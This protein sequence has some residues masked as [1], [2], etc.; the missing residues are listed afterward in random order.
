MPKAMPRAITLFVSVLTLATCA[1]NRQSVTDPREDLDWRAAPAMTLSRSAHAVV[2]DEK[3]IYALG[4]TGV[5]RKPVLAVERFD[6]HE[7]KVETKLPGIGLN[8]PAAAMHN[9]IIYL[10]GGFNTTTNVPSAFVWTY[11]TAGKNWRE[12]RPLPSPRGGHAA[13]VHNGNIHVV[14]GGNAVSTISDHNVFD[15]ATETWRTLAPLPKTTGSPALVSYRGE[16]YAIG[17][18][19]GDSDFGETYVYNT[20]SN[21]WRLGTPV[22]PRGTAGAV[23]ACD[24]IYLIGG[25]SQSARKV[26]NDVLR[27]NLSAGQWEKLTPLRTARNFARAVMLGRDI[28]VVGGNLTIEG[29][30]ESKG[31]AI[32]ERMRPHC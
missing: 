24:A 17:G 2:S 11:D 18:R 7:W 31:S 3:T 10:I 14:G 13:T 32:V 12:T 6:G 29:S 8:A 19:S 26:L 21:T 25:E 20:T 16:L 28:Y 1:A 15:L 23:V 27:L 22:A 5:G 9:G 4:G 30:H